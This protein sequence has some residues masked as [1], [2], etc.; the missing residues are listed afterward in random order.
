MLKTRITEMFGIEYPLI[1]G[2]MLW[3]AR[4]E[5]AAA[6]SNAGG[7]GI[8][9]SATFPTVKELRQE[10]RQAKSL[11]KK[12]FAVNITLL[13]T[14]RP[15]NYEDYIEATIEEGVNIVETSGRSPG[16]YMKLFKDAK[17]KVMHKCARVR[18]AKAAERLGVDAVTII[19]FEAGG[20]PGTEDVT[21]LVRIPIA[22]DAVKIPVIAGGG[23]ADARG[24]VAALALGAEA[25]LMGTRFIAT[26]ECMA[27]PEIKQCLIRATEKDTIMINRVFNNPERVLKTDLSLKV[28]EMEEA[29]ATL[30]DLLPMITGLRGKQALEEGDINQGVIACGEVVGLVRDVPSV[31][32]LVEN[33]ISEAKAVGQRFKST[34]I[35][36]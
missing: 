36:A 33:I 14:F 28:L 11:T 26:R 1:Q 32:E 2:A 4:A 18:D 25:V 29:G 16:P 6:V 17:V 10:I 23:I 5:L 24:L 21:S 31:K 34:G 22:V 7:L 19:G 27:H 3:L 20:N 13:P 30:P 35:V 8:I 15:M 12:P 9:S